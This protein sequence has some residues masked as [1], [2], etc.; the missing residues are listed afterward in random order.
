MSILSHKPRTV[1]PSLPAQ[2]DIPRSH[3]TAPSP[4]AIQ[5]KDPAEH[6]VDEL[7]V[8]SSNLPQDHDL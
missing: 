2:S 5:L 6:E 7:L 4:S 8:W 1:D 3:P